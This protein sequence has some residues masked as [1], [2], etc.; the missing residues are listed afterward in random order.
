M[1][2]LKAGIGHV[3]VRHRHVRS[4]EAELADGHGDLGAVEKAAE[5]F[6]MPADE[7]VASDMNGPEHIGEGA[8]VAIARAE[9]LGVAAIPGPAQIV[10]QPPDRGLLGRRHQF[11]PAM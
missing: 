1:Q 4:E 2:R 8:V 10:Q 6:G 3:D 11:R 5:H 9:R 7:L